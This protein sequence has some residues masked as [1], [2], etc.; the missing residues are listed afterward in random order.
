MANSFI[1]TMLGTTVSFKSNI[2]PALDFNKLRPPII[3]YCDGFFL[4]RGV[5]V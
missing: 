1:F 3:F 2:Y 4:H 5:Q